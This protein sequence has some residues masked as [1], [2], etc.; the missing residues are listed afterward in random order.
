MSND[1][2]DR[3]KLNNDKFDKERKLRKKK[4]RDIQKRKLIESNIYYFAKVTYINTVFKKHV[5]SKNI[6]ILI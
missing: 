1:D 5:S 3:L 4:R 6:Y 2:V